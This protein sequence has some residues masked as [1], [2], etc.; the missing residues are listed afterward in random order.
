MPS[1]LPA[2]ELTYLH[3]CLS[4]QGASRDYCYLVRSPLSGDIPVLSV[5][6]EHFCLINLGP[7]YHPLL[8]SSHQTVSIARVG[9]MVSCLR[10]YIFLTPGFLVCVQSIL[11][12]I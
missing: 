11:K 5:P 7:H 8:M 1:S 4:L 2:T 12:N 9:A 3:V 10:L 6:T